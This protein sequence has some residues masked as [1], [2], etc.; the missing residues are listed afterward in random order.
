MTIAVN[1]LD[2]G[3]FDSRKLVCARAN[4][5]SFGVCAVGE[6]VTIKTSNR[7]KKKKTIDCTLVIRSF[8]IDI[9]A[10]F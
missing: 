3:R 7:N 2:F 4:C 10:L 9:T 5:A 6:A 1:R 8:T